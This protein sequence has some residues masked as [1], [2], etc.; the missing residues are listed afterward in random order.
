MKDHQLKKNQ[1]NRKS[2]VQWDHKIFRVY[3]DGPDFDTLTIDMD[4]DRV[5]HV[6]ID[7]MKDEVEEL[8]FE[9]W[10]YITGFALDDD[11]FYLMYKRPSRNK[12]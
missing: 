2:P 7:D 11:S 6:F 1:N 12:K 5:D 3:S 8:S 10:R 4:S 9:G